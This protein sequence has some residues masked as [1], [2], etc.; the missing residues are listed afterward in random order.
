MSSASPQATLVITGAASG[1]G[2]ALVKHMLDRVPAIVAIDKNA[3]ALQA[4][5]A[6]CPEGQL[7]PVA[8]QLGDA[9]ALK[10]ALQPVLEKHPSI[11]S[12]AHCAGQWCGGS[13]LGT[14]ESQWQQLIESNLWAAKNICGLVAP[15][16]IRAGEGQV[17]IVSSNAARMPRLDMSAYC[18]SKAALSMYAKCL[19]LELARHQV[20]CNILS[21]G[22]TRTAMQAQ[23]QAF[24]AE[25]QT[26]G[27]GLNSGLDTRFRVPAPLEG[28]TEPEDIAALIAFLLSPASRTMTMADLCADRGATLGV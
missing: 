2:R 25:S 26:R 15:G 11:R 1:I 22:A 12:L 17:V 10:Q 24:M 21:P 13:I 6:Q 7:I 14:Q 19:A 23:Y 28:Q 18:V 4:L 3:E 16:L 27:T 8:A 20:R 9:A 5:N